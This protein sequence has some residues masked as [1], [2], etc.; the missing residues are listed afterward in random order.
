MRPSGAQVIEYETTNNQR[1]KP[2]K[3]SESTTPN[4]LKAAAIK[5][6]F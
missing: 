2:L 3:I 4:A 1:F 5:K 6:A